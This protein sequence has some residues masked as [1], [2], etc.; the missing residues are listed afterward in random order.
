M[1]VLHCKSSWQVAL[2]Q[3]AWLVRCLELK[4]FWIM[5]PRPKP[6][7]AWI[8][9]WSTA[10]YIYSVSPR[11]WGECWAPHCQDS[12]QIPISWP[13]ADLQSGKHGVLPISHSFWLHRLYLL[14]RELSFTPILCPSVLALLSSWQ[15]CK[16]TA[17]YSQLLRSKETISHICVTQ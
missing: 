5:S 7:L 2:K 4:V 12:I 1:S 8:N 16:F 15:L 17:V 10:D 13:Q 9:V 11:Y 6:W 14:S 3:P